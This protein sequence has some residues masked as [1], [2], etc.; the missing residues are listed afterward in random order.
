MPNQ[1]EASLA[2]EESKIIVSENATSKSEPF[3][4]QWNQLISTTNW[5]KGEIICQWRDSL[6]ASEVASSDRSDEAWSQLVGGVT[7]QHVGRLRRTFERFGHVYKEYEGV[8]WS[9]FYAALDWD[10]AEMWL[11]GAVQNNW[12]ISGMRQQR[13]ETLG[14]VGEPPSASEVVASEIVEETQSLAISENNRSNDRDYIEGP[15]HEGPDWG[16]DEQPS[17]KGKRETAELDDDVVP[18]QP[19]AIRPF[20]SFTDL[21]DDVM[22]AASAFKVAIIRHKADEWSEMDK[23]DLIG[24]L[25]A[26]KQLAALAPV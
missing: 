9:H 14:K 26:L 20:E 23:D 19:H 5:D 3:I 2:V 13:W 10:D 7:P 12:S 18:A 11:E 25:D 21:P 6:K 1:P 22:E 17:G 4:G 16:D 24:L 15:V 8:F